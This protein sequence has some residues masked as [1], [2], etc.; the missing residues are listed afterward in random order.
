MLSFTVPHQSAAGLPDRTVRSVPVQRQ[1]RHQRQGAEGYQISDR[2]R[3]V[4]TV[5][6][7]AAGQTVADARQVQ[8]G[9]GRRTGTQS[10]GQEQK[11]GPAGER[12]A[13]NHS[14]AVLLR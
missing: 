7:G 3:R 11:Q 13:E 4:R 5:H 1:G 2:L 14:A 10:Q 9:R 12:K 8:G 6:P